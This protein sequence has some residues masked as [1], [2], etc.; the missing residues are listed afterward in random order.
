M[1]IEA[2]LCEHCE[3]RGDIIDYEDGDCPYHELWYVKELNRIIHDM[4]IPLKSLVKRD[5]R[6]I[7]LAIAAIERAERKA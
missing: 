4:L 5:E 1:R 6:I 3:S 7:G 2:D